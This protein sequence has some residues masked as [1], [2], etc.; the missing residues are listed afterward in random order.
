MG[1]NGRIGAILFAALLGCALGADRASA[2]PTLEATLS[3]RLGS[4]ASGEFATLSVREAGDGGL[5]FSIRLLDDLGPLADLNRFY[6]NLPSGVS[7]LEVETLGDAHAPFTLGGG[8]RNRAGNGSR[9]DVAVRF[10][11][12][13]G[14]K[15]NGTLHEAR[16]VIRG[17]QEL[18]LD[19]LLSEQSETR[20][21]IQAHFAARFGGAAEGGGAA[22]VLVS[23]P[24]STPEPGTAFLLG[25]GLVAL[26]ASRRSRG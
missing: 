21:G 6:F 11:R 17:D 10:G 2:T 23:N 26:A 9:F 25:A 18:G 22:A 4:G 12:G 5:E 24:I 16:F 3:V 1:W 19:D 15:G 14:E 8:H 13:R 20:S 7:G